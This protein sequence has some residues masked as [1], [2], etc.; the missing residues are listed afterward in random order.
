MKKWNSSTVRAAKGKERLGCCTAYDACFA[1]LADEAGVPIILVGDSMGNNVLGYET[2][3]PVNIEDSVSAVAAV[4]RGVKNAM[5]VGDMPFGSYQC[6]DDTAMA[7]AVRLVKA[8]ADAVKLEGGVRIAALVRRMTEAGIPVLGH[9]GMTPQ[10]VNE[11]GGFKKQGK[12]RE[13]ADAIMADAKAIEAAG[14][15]AITL[16]CVP[17]ELAAEITAALKVPTVG[18][19]AGPECDAQWLVMHDLLGLNDSSPS[20]VKRYAELGDAAR[21]AFSAYVREV[22]EGAFP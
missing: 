14:A 6:G 9:V 18:I 13:S 22:G 16:E 12:T 17:A 2:T 10:S 21:K 1:R 11:Y 19:G 5:V 4:A 8:G 7:N 3:L 20:F 15:F